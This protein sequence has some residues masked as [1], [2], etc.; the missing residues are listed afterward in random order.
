MDSLCIQN[1]HYEILGGKCKTDIGFIYIIFHGTTDNMP[2]TFR[3]GDHISPSGLLARS[4]RWL[5]QQQ[6]IVRGMP[7]QQR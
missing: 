3:D 6:T 7:F 4:K 2:Y 5:L 1:E